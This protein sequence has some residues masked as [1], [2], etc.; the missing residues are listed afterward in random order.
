M[1]AVSL[2]APSKRFRFWRRPEVCCADWIQDNPMPKSRKDV[3]PWEDHRLC[4]RGKQKACRLLRNTCCLL[5]KRMHG[6]NQK[7]EAILFG[8]FCIDLPEPDLPS[9]STIPL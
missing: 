5:G 4:K 1:K 8:F 9:I 6:R 3:S 7:G 2:E